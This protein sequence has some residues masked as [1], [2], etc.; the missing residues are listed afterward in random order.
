[1]ENL[2]ARLMSLAFLSNLEQRWSTRLQ[3]RGEVFRVASN[4]Q[5][6]VRQ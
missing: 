5:T 3:W 4:G 1:M 6:K 2:G